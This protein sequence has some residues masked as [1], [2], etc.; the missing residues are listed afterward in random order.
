[1]L[2]A[3]IDRTDDRRQLLLAA[4]EEILK[5]EPNTDLRRYARQRYLDLT[6]EQS[7]EQAA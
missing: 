3:R 4:L 7:K 1:M 6:D 5:T 2:P